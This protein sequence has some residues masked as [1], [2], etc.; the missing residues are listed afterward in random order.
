MFFAATGSI[1]SNWSFRRSL[2][3]MDQRI[4]M[5]ML[6]LG[7]CPTQSWLDGERF[8]WTG[9]KLRRGNP[10][11]ESQLWR[12]KFLARDGRYSRASRNMRDCARP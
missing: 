3:R 8:I 10:K 7:N 1:L 9:A 2:S 6:V 11:P 12:G 4:L 5:A